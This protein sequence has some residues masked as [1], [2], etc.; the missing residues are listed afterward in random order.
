MYKK[1]NEELENV[2]EQAKSIC[3][4]SLKFRKKEKKSKNERYNYGEKEI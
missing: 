2:K 4:V 1:F 3:K